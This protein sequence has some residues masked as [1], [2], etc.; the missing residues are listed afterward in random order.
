MRRHSVAVPTENPTRPDFVVEVQLRHFRI[1]TWPRVKYFPR[2]LESEIYCSRNDT[3]K[4]L[5]Y[6]ICSTSE[7]DNMSPDKNGEEMANLCRIWKLEGEETFSDVRESLDSEQVPI[8]VSGQVLEP[9]QL[10]S[11]A[12]IADSEVLILEWKIAIEKDCKF[13]FAYDPKPNARKNR[14]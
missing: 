9:Y 8:S 13:P 14:F 3:V 1:I 12:N 7:F 10:I 6:R 5:I 2:V 11:D 4:E